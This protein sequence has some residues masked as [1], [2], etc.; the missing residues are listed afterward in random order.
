MSEHGRSIARAA[1]RLMIGKP[2]IY[3]A[4]RT[5]LMLLIPGVVWWHL[6]DTTILPIRQIQIT[7]NAQHLDRKSMQRVL[8]HAIRESG[9]F[10][11]DIEVLRTTLL[12][13]ESWLRDVT[14]HRHW[15]DGL[16]LQ[17]T[18]QSAIAKWGTEGL[19]NEYGE[20]F[21]PRGGQTTG[22]ATGEMTEL[23]G[24]TGQGPLL[25]RQSRALKR[26]LQGSGWRLTRLTLTPG[27]AW[28]LHLNDA[29]ELR[30]GRSHYTQR[31]QRA[32]DLLHSDVLMTIGH[33]KAIDL[34]YPNGIAI[35]HG[36]IPTAAEASSPFT[37]GL[38]QHDSTDTLAG[39]DRTAKRSLLEQ[40][41]LETRHE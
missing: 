17:L 26:A 8:H 15:P 32:L 30:L 13:Q 39:L 18:E 9:L 37:S 28:L 36:K 25:L 24:P 10:S 11:V 1:T 27:R 20:A 2:S 22:T 5:I 16:F 4:T 41:S 7:G 3:R 34:R 14:V 40:T 31:L 33:V 38:L 21:W 23:W 12:R 35:E 19:L 6:Q 29:L